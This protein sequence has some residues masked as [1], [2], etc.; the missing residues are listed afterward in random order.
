LTAAA[1]WI[2]CGAAAATALLVAV[3]LR[4]APQSDGLMNQLRG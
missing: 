3:G 2:V 4:A 1:L